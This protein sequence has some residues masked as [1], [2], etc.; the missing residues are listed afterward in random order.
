M[1]EL[2]NNTG[3]VPA[4][5]QQQTTAVTEN[6]APTQAPVQAQAQ[7]PGC[8]GNCKRCPMLQQTYCAAQISYR[9]QNAIASLYTRL[10]EIQE[11]VGR[12]ADEVTALKK[13]YE[14]QPAIIEAPTPDDQP[15]KKKPA[16]K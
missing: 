7:T 10:G 13:K 12:L 6:T 15:K 1:E 5:T 3:A 8:P 2:N 9:M 14:E 16:S 11:Q 4:E